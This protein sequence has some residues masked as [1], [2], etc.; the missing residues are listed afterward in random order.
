[1]LES[2]CETCII[3]QDA[4]SYTPVPTNE[5]VLAINP[6]LAIDAYKHHLILEIDSV[7]EGH[8]GGGQVSR[9][10]QPCTWWLLLDPLTLAVLLLGTCTLYAMLTDNV[11]L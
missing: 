4:D 2:T 11:L 9:H 10:G 5:T 8:G 3:Y 7:L 6:S 1:M